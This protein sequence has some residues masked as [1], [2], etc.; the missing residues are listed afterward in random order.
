M[1]SYEMTLIGSASAIMR[2][3]MSNLEV[4]C[5]AWNP[6]AEALESTSFLYGGSKESSKL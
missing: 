3:T 6:V 1:A 5:N 2:G 4:S